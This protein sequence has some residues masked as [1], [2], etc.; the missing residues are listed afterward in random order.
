MKRWISIL[1]ACLLLPACA[2]AQGLSQGDTGDEVLALQQRLHALGLSTGRADGIYGKQTASAVEEAQ[3]LLISA[4]Y[5]VQQTGQADEDTLRLLY[6]E[7]AQD[8]LQTLLPGSRGDRVK[9]L[10]NRLIDLGM[11]AAAADGIYGVQTQTAVAAF[12]ERMAELGQ[13]VGSVEG[14]ATPEVQEWLN[15]DLSQYGLRAPIYFDDTDPASL[16]A[17]DLYASACILIDAPSGTVLFERNADERMYPASTTKIMTLLVALENA[18]L[19]QQVTVPQCAAEIPADSSRVPVY[20]GEEMRMVDLLYG[21]M[22]RSGNDAANAVAQLCAG[23][24][25]GFVQQMNAKAQSLGMTGTHYMNPHGYHDEA[26]Y[27]TARDLA[28]VTRLG[29]TDATFCQIVTC[30]Q[31]TLPATQRREALTLTNSYEIFDSSS[32]SYIPGAAGVKSGYTSAAGF[33]YVGAAQRGNETLIAVIMGEP[34][35]TCGWTDLRRLFEYG[36]ALSGEEER[37]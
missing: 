5:G 26:H 19:N 2:L 33:C 29:L 25:E 6:D 17:Q 16:T 34:N 22:I 23:S 27:S 31:Y 30:L 32:G 1:L 11:T 21:L 3:R 12:Q 24:V 37:P 20:P 13:T 14:V 18:D 7:E 10:Q 9:Q 36:F 4:G 35:R 15:A 28:T 8:A